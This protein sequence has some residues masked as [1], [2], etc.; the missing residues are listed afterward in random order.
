[1]WT[2]CN[3]FPIQKDGNYFPSCSFAL[4][5]EISPLPPQRRWELMEQFVI[6]SH[7]IP[8]MAGGFVGLLFQALCSSIFAHEDF[9]V[10]WGFL[11]AGGDVFR[12]Q[13]WTENM[14]DPVPDQS[15]HHSRSVREDKIQTV[16]SGSLAAAAASAK[17]QTRS[18][19]L[20]ISIITMFPLCAS[21]LCT[22]SRSVSFSLSL[23]AAGWS[24]NQRSENISACKPHREREGETK[25]GCQ[26]L[27][28]VSVYI[29]K[30]V[31]V[32][33]YCLC[34]AK[35]NKARGCLETEKNYCGRSKSFYM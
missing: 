26:S 33:W 6:T 15:S 25:T 34:L 12:A 14:S 27:V 1:M 17:S 4:S 13:I 3:K 11:R 9:I 28:S 22:S 10:F 7:H 35:Q 8:P 32:Y 19:I 5:R 16:T 23:R 24:L 2:R 20:V 29:F 21:L 31:N 30:P 18:D